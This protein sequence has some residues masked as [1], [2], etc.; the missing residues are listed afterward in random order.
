LGRLIPEQ[1]VKIF[2]GLS[3]QI[4]HASILENLQM[5]RDGWTGKM[6]QFGNSIHIKSSPLSVGTIEQLDVDACDYATMDWSMARNQRRKPHPSWVW[7]TLLAGEP[8][9]R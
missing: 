5:M 4:D 8:R 1:T 2:S 6:H 7:P 3:S 9:L